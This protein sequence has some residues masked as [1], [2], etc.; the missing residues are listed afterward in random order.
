MSSERVKHISC[1]H[2]VLTADMQLM[3][4]MKEHGT[5]IDPLVLR[6]HD[7]NMSIEL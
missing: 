4:E 3:Y 2:A 7:R 5:D 6:F 1:S